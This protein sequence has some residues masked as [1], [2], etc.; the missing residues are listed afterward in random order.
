MKNQ[1]I[2]YFKIYSPSKLG[3]FSECP[4]KYYFF[5]IDPIYSK[6]K[7]ELKNKPE[8]IWHFNTLGKAIHNAITLFYHLPTKER[9]RD[10]LLLGL[11]QTWKSEVI[12][13]KTYPLGQWGGFHSI[14]EEREYYGDALSMLKNFFKVSEI[15]PDIYYLPTKEFQNSIEDF[16]DSIVPLTCDFD[17]GGKFDLILEKKGFLHLIDFKTGKGEDNDFFQLRFYKLLTELKFKK[18]VKEASYYF[19]RTGNIKT[20]SFKKEENDKTKEEIITK[21]K[22]IRSAKEFETRP[23]KLCKFCLF[24]TFCPEKKEVADIIKDVKKEDYPDDLPF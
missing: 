9:T 12:R 20:L 19:L 10:N 21:I 5:Y 15:N 4:K 16:H 13:N 3:L 11:R 17:I 23:G 1:R 6:M 2:N 18:K 24:K 7:N 14:D 8:N 22:E